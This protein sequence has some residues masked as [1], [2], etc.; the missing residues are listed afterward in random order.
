MKK[1]IMRVVPMIILLAGFFCKRNQ[2]P[3]LI[4]ANFPSTGKVNVVVYFKLKAKDPEGKEISFK[5]DFGDNNQSGWS[6]YILTESVYTDTHIYQ[7]PGQFDINVKIKDIEGKETEWIKTG[8]IA[9]APLEIG[10]IFWIFTCENN[11]E[12]AAFYSTPII[13]EQDSVIYVA[14]EFGHLHAIK[15]NGEEKWHFSLLEEERVVSSPLMDDYKYIYFL[16]EE[17]KFLS[18]TKEGNRRWERDLYNSF[19]ASPALGKF[20]EIYL[21]SEDSIFAF[22]NTG[23]LLWTKR[24]AGGNNSPIVDEEGN[25][26]F[27]SEKDSAIFSFDANGWL[28]FEFRFNS[29]VVNSP[30]F[31]NSKKILFGLED[32]RIICV[33]IRGETLWSRNLNEPI[34]SSGVV[35]DDSVF[36]LITKYGSV[37]QGDVNGNFLPIISVSCDLTSSLVISEDNCLY[38]R[39]SWEEEEYDTLYGIDLNGNVIFRTPIPGEDESED[40]EI[41][42]SPKI[43]PDGTIYISTAKGLYAIV[44]K[45]KPKN[46][47]WYSFRKDNRNTG[48]R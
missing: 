13:D 34:F 30:F 33:D 18:L 41:L 8:K 43:G 9:I 23:E 32:N 27:A 5:L 37:F 10:E 3:E 25:I 46:T 17:G 39:A 20:N 38:F 42:S 1:S 40:W 24:V 4:E 28:R 7:N 31:I 22:N 14:C 2:P 47:G 36:Y 15:F 29:P 19:Y 26:Y 44:G 45:G 35:L 11:G 6:P 16:T 48:R 21:Q 12:T